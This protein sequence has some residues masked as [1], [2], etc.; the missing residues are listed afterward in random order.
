MTAMMPTLRF[1]HM[2]ISMVSHTSVED[3]RRSWTKEYTGLVFKLWDERRS[4]EQLRKLRAARI[5]RRDADAGGDG[6]VAAADGAI[7]RLDEAVDRGGARTR[8]VER[9][10]AERFP[11][12]LQDDTLGGGTFVS[13]ARCDDVLAAPDDRSRAQMVKDFA[14]ETVVIGG[15][16]RAPAKDD[17]R[18]HY[19]ALHG[20]VR[21]Q[22]A[23][24]M[25]V[26]ADGAIAAA[27]A[28]AALRA[29]WR[30]R[31]GADAWERAQKHLAAASLKRRPSGDAVGDAAA[32]PP[33]PADAPQYAL[34]SRPTEPL[35][36]IAVHA[37]RV[38][39]TAHSHLCEVRCDADADDGEATKGRCG[40]E[41][42]FIPIASRTTISCK[43]GRPRDSD[44]NLYA[45]RV[46]LSVV[47]IEDPCDDAEENDDAPAQ[48][49]ATSPWT[50][51]F[52]WFLRSPD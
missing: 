46:V 20:R 33:P 5:E 15:A 30:T 24:A 16:P 6:D 14:R 2:P 39:A 4:V 12:M 44:A 41:R 18:D 19:A 21:R 42:A 11:G 45:E 48:P 31:V 17:G 23:A 10:L 7:A 27:L 28:D 25:R 37:D 9:Q 52:L 49:R 22:C 26:D 3:R 8:D 32:P 36:T 38:V 35:T 47:L 50:D 13:R 29:S 34:V 51:A 1:F 43:D 40:D